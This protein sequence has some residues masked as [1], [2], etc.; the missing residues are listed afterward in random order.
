MTIDYAVVIPTIGRDNLGRLLQ[1]FAAGSGQAPSEVVVV[2]D[3][4]G[5]DGLPPLVLPEMDLRVRVVR[6][7]GRGPAAARNVGWHSTGAEWIAFLDDDVITTDQWRDVLVSDL[8][9]Q[10]SDVVASTGRIIVPPPAGRK[11]T[12]AER[13]TASLASAQ[14]ITA[15]MAVRREALV[16]TG[17]FDERFRRAFREDA[18]LA[19]RL[20]E[21]GGRIVDGARRTVHPAAAGDFWTSAREQ[22]GNAD[23]ALMRYKHGARWRTKIGESR[24]RI[25]RYALTCLA[26]ATAFGAAVTGRRTTSVVA[27]SLWTALTTEFAWRRIAPGPRDR[28]EVLR[29]L[30]TSVVIPPLACRHRA[31]GELRVRTGWHTAPVSNKPLALLFDRD[32]TLIRDVPY[33]A[34]PDLVEPMPGAA[35]LLDELRAAGYRIGVVSNQSGVARG[36]ITP[37]QLTAVNERVHAILGDFDTWQTCVHDDSAGC[38]CRKPAPGMIKAAAAELGIDTRDCVM[39]GDIGADVE[40]A[41]SAGASAILVPTGKTRSDEIDRARERA[42]VAPDL[43]SAVALATVGAR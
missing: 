25:P 34:D 22:I 26:A 6:S 11:P 33:L 23:N 1:E 36:L 4:P 16:D 18:D 42:L 20:T 38:D 21:A 24:G 5:A 27:A 31:H 3:R 9:G 12:D 39:I 14:W 13:G 40:A 37:D 28:A 2:D 15:D 43:R 17:G 32:D 35:A 41:L 19:L 7:G 10:P 29:M 8:M 30:V